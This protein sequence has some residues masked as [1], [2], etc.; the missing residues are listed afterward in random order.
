VLQHSVN[1]AAG[2]SRPSGPAA[3]GPEWTY[4]VDKHV[5]VPDTP[6]GKSADDLG[7]HP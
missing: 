6:G 7:T 1:P 3:L 4:A 2:E 5:A